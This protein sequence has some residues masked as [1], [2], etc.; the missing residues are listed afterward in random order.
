LLNLLTDR[1]NVQCEGAVNRRR[2]G[3]TVWQRSAAG[4]QQMRGSSSLWRA[5]PNS[6]A[7][8]SGSLIGG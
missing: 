3:R 8:G 1:I 2:S 5:I 7:P 6:F 4:C